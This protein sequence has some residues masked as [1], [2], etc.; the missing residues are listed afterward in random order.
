M[1]MR[2]HVPGWLVRRSVNSGLKCGLSKFD[3]LSPRMRGKNESSTRPRGRRKILCVEI[4]PGRGLVG[5][6]KVTV[7]LLV[8]L[9]PSLVAF[10]LPLFRCGC[11]WPC[12]AQRNVGG[13]PL[14]LRGRCIRLS[15]RPVQ[16]NP[17]VNTNMSF[18]QVSWKK[19]NLVGRE[20]LS[21]FGSPD[22][23]VDAARWA[24]H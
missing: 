17:I 20:R 2:I 11:R 18:A 16:T 8:Q 22:R 3:F 6:T 5:K 9:G 19:S 7:M 1:R 15:S 24:A 10:L 13:K 12:R 14:R 21:R 4:R 23:N